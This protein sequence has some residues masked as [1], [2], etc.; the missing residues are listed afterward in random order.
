MILFFSCL[1]R[2][3][4][5]LLLAAGATVASASADGLVVVHDAGGTVDAA[6]Y[7]ERPALSEAI[8]ARALAVAVA[9]LGAA[10]PVYEPVSLP[11]SPDPLRAGAPSRMRIRGLTRP[12]FAIGSDP[13]SLE[14][15][16]SNAPRL[17]ERGAQG[18]L[19]S[20]P[21]QEAVAR[22]RA[23]AARLGLELDPVSGAA[24]ADAYG[25]RSYPF[26]AEPSP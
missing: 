5:V 7:L 3:A 18:F 25:A 22:S 13:A 20:A 19:V 4:A 15:L 6:P 2:G 26:A 1:Y 9:L 17:R 10:A 12:V 24:L 23:F 8:R 16:A 21:S 11:V 14:W